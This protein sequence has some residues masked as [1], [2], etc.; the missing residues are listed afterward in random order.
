MCVLNLGYVFIFFG[1]VRG[2]IEDHWTR[3]AFQSICIQEIKVHLNA[4]E[5]AFLET[6]ELDSKYD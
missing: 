6:D 3:C 4:I 1:F 2:M 5:G